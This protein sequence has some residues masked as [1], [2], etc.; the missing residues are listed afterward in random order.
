M[1]T[2]IKKIASV[3]LAA[4]LL[5]ITA[6]NA[7]A[8]GTREIASGNTLF[9]LSGENSSKYGQLL[10][11]NP[12]T[13]APT[14]V[15]TRGSASNYGFAYQAAYNPV[16]KSIYWLSK[17][18]NNGIPND[19]MKANPTTGQSVIVGPL[20]LNGNQIDVQSM[21]IGANGSAYGLSDNTLY[22]VN[23]NTGALTVISSS[24]P[25]D[26]WYSFAYNPA[27]HK[28]YAVTN[29]ANG[30]LVEIN[31]TDGTVTGLIPF[32]NFPN[33][34]AGTSTSAKRTF[35]IAF[36]QNGSLW[37]INLDGDIF[38]TLVTG[39][40]NADFVTG[41]QVVG[42]PGTTAT[43]GITIAYNYAAGSNEL[44]NTGTNPATINSFGAAALLALIAGGSL[45]F[46]ARRKNS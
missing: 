40:N 7:S 24:L 36:D 39:A 14:E 20:T 3:V 6:T 15:G 45:L 29:N 17:D 43:N 9:A 32:S 42:T 11:L 26:R 41:I 2:S 10:T 30:G 21:A 28:F 8:V 18:F 46:L 4:A 34:G 33:L 19:L 31:V 13:A 22:S 16:N 27:D 23:L 1:K 38:T 44:A 25:A 35:S 12:Q 5:S 37:G